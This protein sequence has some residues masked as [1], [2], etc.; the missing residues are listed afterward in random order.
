MTQEEKILGIVKKTIQ[1]TE[2]ENRINLVGGAVR[3]QIMGS[4]VDDLDFVV[5]GNI[6]AGLDFAIW[7]C[8]KWG[9][10]KEGSNPV[11]FPNYGTANMHYQDVKLEFVAPRKE[12]Y[13]EGSRNPVVSDGV[14][15]DDA[16]R[17]DLTINS[18]M[19]N[20]STN[21]IVDL[22]GKGLSDIKQGIIRTPSDPKIIFKDDPLRMLRVIRFAVKYN[23]KF[24]EGM[25]ENIKKYAK[26]IDTISKER[27]RDE[28]NKILITKNPSEGIKLLK[29]SGL[30]K[31]VIEEFND[32]IGMGQN[33]YHTEDVFGHSMSV[34]ANT[35]G[36]LKT[37]LIALFHDIG[38]VLTR[39]VEADGAVHFYRHEEMSEKMVRQIMARLKYPNEL[40]DAV[41][42]GVREH[43]SLKSGKDDASQLS[44]KTL[45]KFAARVGDNLEHILDVIHADN[46]SH[47]DESAMKNQIGIVRKRLESL[48]TQVNTTTGK[49]P[50]N[51]D[52]VKKILGVKESPMIG[53]ILNTVKEAW[54][55]NP[56]M[57]YDEA[58]EIVKN[59][60]LNNQINE[61]KR[62]MKTV[63]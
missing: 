14:L 2:W 13:T 23:F 34:L 20:I 15:M 1:G 7:L 12:K 43:M 54:F 55:E 47:A 45:R 61:I 44:D 26:W 18:L 60:E 56:G 52:D 4:P 5:E 41:A 32:A 30:L 42:M 39:T 10:Y 62:I 27:V 36:D 24:G 37:R 6:S 17:R 49:P 9:V 31:Y 11:I 22:T 8:K 35:P 40:I 46:I 51:G 19:R 59:F 3:D 33:Q 50:I 63:I 21:Q 29:D 57:T 28:L 25:L 38:K 53:K 48:N 58:A 16:M